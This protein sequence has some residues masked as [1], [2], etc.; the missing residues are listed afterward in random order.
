MRS[1]ARIQGRLHVA[2]PATM[3]QGLMWLAGS[4]TF[5]C[6]PHFSS[7]LE[8]GC[9]RPTRKGQWLR[10]KGRK[11]REGTLYLWAL[12]MGKEF[13][14][15]RPF[16]ASAALIPLLPRAKALS[17]SLVFFSLSCSLKA[18][19]ISLTLIFQNHPRLGRCFYVSNFPRFVYY[20][21]NHT[22]YKDCLY[23]WIIHF[24]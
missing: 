12:C 4:L 8:P 9:S 24:P 7:P 11:T 22:C 17:L 3:S 1:L 2:I 23:V 21:S 18:F 10:C 6:M 5:C 16:S 14:Q 19:P 15:T 20:K 13:L